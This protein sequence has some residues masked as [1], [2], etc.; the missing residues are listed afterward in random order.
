MVDSFRCR[1]GCGACC[2]VISI[3]SSIPGMENGKPAGTRCINLDNNN[4]CLLFGKKERPKVCISLTP[5][6]EM[7][8]NS[9]FDAVKYLEIIEKETLP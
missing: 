1:P 7:C 5:S 6:K 3:S 2:I 8:G 4:L 9:Y